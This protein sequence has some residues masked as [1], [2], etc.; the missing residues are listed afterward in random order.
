MDEK[1]V[2]IEEVRAAFERLLDKIAASQCDPEYGQTV[3][4]AQVDVL[5]ILAG[6]WDE[7][8][9]AAE[10]SYSVGSYEDQLPF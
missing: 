6:K 3:Y 5:D 4:F 2:T 1:R 7:V 10:D 9:D 8:E